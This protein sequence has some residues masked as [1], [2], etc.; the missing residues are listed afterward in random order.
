MCWTETQSEN[1]PQ[2][3]SESVQEAGTALHGQWAAP[4]A[5]GGGSWPTSEAPH[6]TGGTRAAHRG[7]RGLAWSTAPGAGRKPHWVPPGD[8]V[9]LS[10]PI[11]TEQP[12]GLQAFMGSEGLRSEQRHAETPT[13][14]NR[15]LQLQPQHS[16]AVDMCHTRATRV[17]WTLDA[18]GSPTREAQGAA[19]QSGFYSEEGFFLSDRS[20][21]DGMGTG[22]GAPETLTTPRLVPSCL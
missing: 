11:P 21:F 8:T 16:A 10:L 3:G 7:L 18:C 1:H 13:G 6:R 19:V 14:I 17:P 2:P 15:D 9:G 12:V 4:R 22:R 20:G 5:V